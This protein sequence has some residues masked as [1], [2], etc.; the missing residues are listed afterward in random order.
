MARLLAD[1]LRGLI[2]PTPY[3]RKLPNGERIIRVDRLLHGTAQIAIGP[4]DSWSCDDSWIYRSLNAALAAAM[5]WN[6]D[7]DPEPTGWIHHLNT[8]RRRPEG[9]VTR[10]WN[11]AQDL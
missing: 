10:E 11:P 7:E 3:Q 1:L 5:K 6:P 4:A 8:G 2:D 9:D